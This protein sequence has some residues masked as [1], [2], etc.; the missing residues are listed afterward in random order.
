MSVESVGGEWEEAREWEFGL[1]L[2]LSNKIIF[3]KVLSEVTWTL[4]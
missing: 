2:F 1:I 4:K 3:K